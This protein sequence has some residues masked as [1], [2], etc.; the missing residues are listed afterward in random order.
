MV[1]SENEEYGKGVLMLSC[2]RASVAPGVVAGLLTLGVLALWWAHVSPAS[3]QSPP[4]QEIREC[5]I[6]VLGHLP[7][8]LQ[9]LTNEQRRAVE[10]DCPRA[11]G[12]LG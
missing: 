6:K 4:I 12:R 7:A 10:R 11:R 9:E 8:N 5:I 2:A 3:A 1:P